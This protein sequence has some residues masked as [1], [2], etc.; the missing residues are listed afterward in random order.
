MTTDADSVLW[1]HLTPGLGVSTLGPW[2]RGQ[3]S[4]P[5]P[6]LSRCSG[7]F[8]FHTTVSTVFVIQNFIFKKKKN[9]LT[10]TLPHHQ[11]FAFSVDF[12]GS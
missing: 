3:C 12:A 1:T 10:R 9:P 5:L 8:L 2:T 7:E 6:S 11:G 4:S